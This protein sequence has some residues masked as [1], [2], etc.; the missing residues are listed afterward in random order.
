M[1]FL[2]ANKFMATQ[3]GIKH[4]KMVAHFDFASHLATALGILLA[5]MTINKLGYESFL[6]GLLAINIAIAVIGLLVIV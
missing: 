5:G 3:P 4:I 2:S 6:I 1:A